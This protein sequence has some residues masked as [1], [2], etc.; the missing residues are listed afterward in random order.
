MDNLEIQ[1]TTTKKK[2]KDE[3]QGPHLNMF[4]FMLWT[5]ILPVF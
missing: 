5:L 2:E 3:E 4:C 1:A